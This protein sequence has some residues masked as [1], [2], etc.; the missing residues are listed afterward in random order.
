MRRRNPVGDHLRSNLGIISRPAIICG[1]IWG[2]FPVR[3]SFA[4][5]DH[6]RACTAGQFM[7]ILYPERKE[8]SGYKITVLVVLREKQ[9][10]ARVTVIQ[11]QIVTTKKQQQQKTQQ[12]Q[13]KT[14]KYTPNQN[15]APS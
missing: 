11:K 7:T 15:E 1:P 13:Q 2:S 12:Q 6:L 9:T 14:L 4:G 10:L 8:D 3:G 5:R